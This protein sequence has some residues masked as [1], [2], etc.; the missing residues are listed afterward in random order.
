[1][2]NL[3]GGGSVIHPRSD[4]P[5]DSVLGALKQNMQTMKMTF[6]GILLL[7]MEVLPNSLLVAI[8]LPSTDRTVLSLLTQKCITPKQVCIGWGALP[9]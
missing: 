5:K 8:L 4:Q 1:M 3:G 7:K 6:I 2:K 9:K